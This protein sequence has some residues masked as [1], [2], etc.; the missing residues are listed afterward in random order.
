MNLEIT[1]KYFYRLGGITC[2]ILLVYSLVTILIMVF[3]GTPPTTIEETFSMLKENRFNGLLRLDILT[4]FVMPFYYLLFYTLYLALKDLNNELVLIS[5]ILVFAGLTLFLAS[6]SVFSYLH[7]SDKYFNAATELEKNQFISA[8]HAIQASD[9][10]NGTGAKIGG[11]LIQI[12]ALLISIVMLKGNVFNKITAWTG[13]VTHGLDFF[14][15][16]IGFFLPNLGIVLMM[17]AG[18][19]YLLWFPLVGIRLFKIK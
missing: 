18:P 17:V 4:V 11:L 10:W 2:I 8:G 5:T 14:H 15:I 7:L 1:K 19:L 9:I 13:I 12:G 3:I 16:L 6:P